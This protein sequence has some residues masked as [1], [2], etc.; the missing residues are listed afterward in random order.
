MVSRHNKSSCTIVSTFFSAKR[1][2]LS[3]SEIPI[4]ANLIW[5][6]SIKLHTLSHTP[7]EHPS[8]A[9]SL[10][11]EYLSSCSQPW[12]Y[13]H[14]H[15]IQMTVLRVLYQSKSLSHGPESLKSSRLC[16]E[17]SLFLL[18]NTYIFVQRSSHGRMQIYARHKF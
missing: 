18:Y 1:S 5:L 6:E 11:H 12:S 2:A 3:E 17:R 10:S 4:G 8:Y 16:D 14:T 13:P 7:V 15:A 9:R